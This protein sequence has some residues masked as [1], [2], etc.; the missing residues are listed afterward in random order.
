MKELQRLRCSD[1]RKKADRHHLEVLREHKPGLHS[2][3][4]GQPQSKFG[5]QYQSRVSPFGFVCLWDA[6]ISGV[7]PPLLAENQRVCAGKFPFVCRCA[8]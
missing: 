3:R 7:N 8:G 5:L 6:D 2:G 1:V 4:S